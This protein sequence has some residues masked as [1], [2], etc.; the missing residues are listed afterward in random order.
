[1]WPQFS[2]VG[3][4]SE[5]SSI[6]NSSLNA[7]TIDSNYEIRKHALCITM[8]GLSCVQYVHVGAKVKQLRVNVLKERGLGDEATY[9]TCIICREP[10]F[11]KVIIILANSLLIHC[12][13]N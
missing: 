7:A 4:N 10:N 11:S 8:C 6:F 9:C 13:P 12:F 2:C 3:V 5:I 1:M